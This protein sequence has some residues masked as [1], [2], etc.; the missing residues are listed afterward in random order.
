MRTLA[1]W[2]AERWLTEGLFCLVCGCVLSTLSWID[3]ELR[4]EMIGFWGSV[5]LA[6]KTTHLEELTANRVKQ[7]GHRWPY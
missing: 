2:I 7:R 5:R 1:E 3:P 4:K 6:I